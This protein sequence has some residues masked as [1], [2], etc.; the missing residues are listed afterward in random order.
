MNA[1]KI[2]STII[3]SQESIVSEGGLMNYLDSL[4]LDLND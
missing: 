2:I 1:L 3:F 4:S